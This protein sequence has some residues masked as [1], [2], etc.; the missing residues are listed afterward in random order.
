MHSLY[1]ER[2]DKERTQSWCSTWQDR[3]TNEYH[4]AWNAWKRCRKK[5][6]SQGEHY[7]HVFTIDSS[8]I[9]FIVN[10]NSQSDGQN[11]SAKSGTNLQRKTIHIVSL[12]RK[13]K[14]TKDN[15]ILPWTNPAKMDSWTS[16]RFSSCCLYEKI[17]YT[18]SQTN[19]LKSLFF[20]NNTVYGIPHQAHR[21]GTSLNGIGSDLIRIF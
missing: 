4:V 13:R 18:A 20:R 17:V 12:Q 15:G 6:E 19:I 8:E 16:I 1:P 3:G 21:G 10:H 9:Q 7:L 14:D 2:R 11:K 5:V